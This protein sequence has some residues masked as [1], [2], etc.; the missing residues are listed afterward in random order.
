MWASDESKYILRWTVPPLAL[1]LKLYNQNFNFNFNAI[2]EGGG[3][4]PAKTPQLPYLCPI[5]GVLVEF[6][7]VCCYRLSISVLLCPDRVCGPTKDK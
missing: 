4:S 6:H 1:A 5:E 2:Q 3:V 7:Q